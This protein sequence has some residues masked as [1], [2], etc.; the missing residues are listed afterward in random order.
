MTRLEEVLRANEQIPHKQ[1]QLEG[2][3][4][5]T[6]RSD[7]ARGRT[8]PN[9]FAICDEVGAG[10]TKTVVDS[11]QIL[12]AR[13]WIDTVLVVGP[14]Y[15]RSTWAD[16]DPV[17][18]ELAKHAWNSVANVVFE[19]HGSRTQVDW[20]PNALNWVI[21]NFE[22]LRSTARRDQMIK[23]LKTR[24]VWMV[25]DESWNIK[26]NSQQTR[27]CI[28]VR[29]K[30]AEM[31]TI[32]NGTPLPEGRPVDLYYQFSF[33]DQDIIGCKSFAHFKSEFCVMG[34]E[35]NRRI[36][37]YKNQDELNRRVAPYVRS[38]RTRDCFD[39]PPMLDP[40][41][42]E[43]PF[44]AENWGHYRS[45]RDDMAVWLDGQQSVSKQAVVK[46]LRLVQITSGFLGGLVDDPAGA[47]GQLPLN[48]MPAWLQQKSGVKP[49]E[50]AKTVQSQVQAFGGP[51][52]TGPVQLDPEQGVPVTREIGREK[53]DALLTWLR[54]QRPRPERLIT[55]CR[56]R[57]ELE[58][59]TKAFLAPDGKRPALFK[60]V[61]NLKGGQSDD[62]RRVVKKLLAPGS[63]QKG[64]VVGITGTGAASLNFS[65]ARLMIFLSHDPRLIKR[66]QSIGRIERP[67]QEGPMLIVD[68]IATG[69][70]GQKTVDHGILK[71]LRSRD[72]MSKWSVKR[73][74]ELVSDE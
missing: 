68:V 64:G 65:A 58:R 34:G 67:G 4:H 22:Y 71:S 5:L 26:G 6:S 18:G 13:R 12:W 55:W 46:M 14:G 52:A 70:K 15:A 38:V 16:P 37:D 53:L 39:L 35:N 47:P 20:E 59:T 28:M 17:I 31:A 27:A 7:P 54:S 33:L 40:I 44:N 49:H 57:P 63:T 48:T 25:V 61:L 29:R 19:W 56:F 21:T 32:L 66:T 42:I 2:V 10:K 69:P 72:D 50:Q 74:R 45:M 73:W 9:A 24:R 1:H 23:L 51:F 36:L 62:E 43:A 41:T 3:V 11:A 60:K 30:R 8:I